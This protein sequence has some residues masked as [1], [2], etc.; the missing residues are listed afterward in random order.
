MRKVNFANK[1]YYHI[2][3]RGTDKRLIFTELNELRRFFQSMDEFN[4]L[5]PIGSIYENSFRKDQFGSRASKKTSK[6]K[7]LVN[8][9]CYCLNPNHFHFILEQLVDRGIEKFMHRLGTGYT[10]YFNQKHERSGVLFQ[11]P[12]KAVH[13]DVNEYLL[14]LSIYVNLNNKIHK[15]QQLGS[16]ASK[17]LSKSSWDEYIGKEDG[18]C[19]KGIILNQFKS[20]LE[21]KKF[22]ENS[23]KDIKARKDIE[24]FLLE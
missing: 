11:G 5:E 7:K 1:E 2:F 22:A 19:E 13:I 24:E 21:Y 14:H 9:I 10:K 3:N 16:S 8:F 15:I 18:F 4:S 20:V 23:L 17:L 12:F 6:K